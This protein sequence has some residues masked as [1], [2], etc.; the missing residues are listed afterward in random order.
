MIFQPPKLVHA[1]SLLWLKSGFNRD[2]FLRHGLIFRKKKTLVHLVNMICAEFR[3]K[4]QQLNICSVCRY[5][6]NPQDRQRESKLSRC[7]HLYKMIRSVLS[8]E[9]GSSCVTNINCWIALTL[10]GSKPTHNRSTEKV[11]KLPPELKCNVKE[12]I[13]LSIGQR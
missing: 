7:R 2:H 8:T 5:C 9:P 3:M 11:G 6:E 4:R 12:P 10:P 13:Y 1:A